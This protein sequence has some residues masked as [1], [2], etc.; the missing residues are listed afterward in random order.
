M[1]GTI[2]LVLRPGEEGYIVLRC[3]TDSPKFLRANFSQVDSR[4]KTTNFRRS[5][6]FETH[7]QK[8]A[9]LGLVGCARQKWE[10][11]FVSCLG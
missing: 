5:E 8:I 7:F 11:V 6:S 2:L 3:V 4:W 9:S 1:A 10:I